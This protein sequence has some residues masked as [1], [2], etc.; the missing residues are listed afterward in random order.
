MG[1]GVRP[2]F[3]RQ[4]HQAGAAASRHIHLSTQVADGADDLHDARHLLLVLGEVVFR[5]H[6]GPALE[7]QEALAAGKILV[8]LLGE[9]GHEGVKQLQQALQHIQQHRAGRGL[10]F[11]VLARQAGLG[12]LDV[13]VAEFTPR[14]VVN[15]GGGQAEVALLVVGCHVTH[16]ILEAGQNPLVRQFQLRG[17]DFLPCVDVHQHEAGGVPHLVGEIAGCFH[18]VAG[19]AGIVTGAHAHQQGEAQRVRAILV[20]DLQRIHTVAQGLG[21]LP[22]QL[23]AHQAVDQHRPE[24]SFA[25]LLHAAGNH[26]ADPEGDDV[27]ARH[28]HIGGIEVLQILGVVRPAQGGEGPQ[29]R[30][31]PGIQHVLVLVDVLAAAL[32]ALGG[33]LTAHHHFTAFVAVPHGDP[34]APPQLAAHAPV[35]DVLHP[36]HVL[37]G[38]AFGH[39]LGLAAGHSL[40][41]G[42]GQGLH[43]HKPLLGHHGLDHRLG[44]AVAHAHLMLDGFNGL[45]Q[46]Q[47]LHV[48]HDGLA[49]FIRGHAGILAAVQHLGFV[50]AGLAGSKQLVRRRLVRCAGHVAIVGEHPHNGQIVPLTHLIVVGVMGGGD[51]HHAGALLHIRVLVAHDGNLPVDKG[52]HHMAAVQVSIALIRRIDGHSGVAQHGF[53]AGGSQLQQFAG[54]LHRI[55]Q[56]PEMT[57]HFLMLHLSVGNSGLALGAP[58][59]Q[60]VAAVD[61][62]LLIQAAEGFPHG[63][64]AALV[65]G[66]ALAAPVAAHA[67]AA[68]LMHNASAVL[69][70]PLP[71]TLEESLPAQAFLGQAL[72][73][74]GFDDFHLGCDGCMVGAG[75]PQGG[76]ALHAVIAGGRVLQGAVHGMAHVQLTGD[77]GRGHHDGK[78]LLALHAVGLKGASLLPGLIDFTFDGLGVELGFH[79]LCSMVGFHSF[80]PPV[81]R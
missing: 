11:A 43:V 17:V 6:L 78:G 13:P 48:R 21:H 27:I 24:G 46:P 40:N 71:G 9:E 14:K 2:A 81:D 59:H 63:L 10:A 66:E 20:N 56:V 7:H 12:Q 1:Q 5:L 76:V 50:L 58:V 47:R 53:R 29:S 72:L 42:L 51:L 36:V 19:I 73:A 68:L 49:G 67:H 38:E 55:Q 54:L 28:Q 31:E 45:Q 33:I 18:L 69:F 30:G 41:G 16:R 62:A 23:V 64:G 79:L 77:I 70:L 26:A 80:L 74:H 25:H 52:Q 61:E 34:V 3:V 22:A 57:V 44:V 15:A 4:K 8:H 37:L 65:H 35:A 60:A 75:E 32:A 39:K